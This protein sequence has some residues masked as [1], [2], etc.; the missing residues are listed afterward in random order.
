M[1]HQGLNRHRLAQHA[2]EKAFAD[3]WEKEAPNTLGYLIGDVYTPRDEEVAA[4]IIQWLGSPVGQWFIRDVLAVPV[5]KEG[6]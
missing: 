4:T 6:Q 3:R 2:L 5:S 1:A